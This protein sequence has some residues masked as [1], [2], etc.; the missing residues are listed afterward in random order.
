MNEYMD[1]LVAVDGSS[2]AKLALYKS[3]EMIKLEENARLHHRY[4]F[5]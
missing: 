1:I 3:T 2:E 5:N 4:L